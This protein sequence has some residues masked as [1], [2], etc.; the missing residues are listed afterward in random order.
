MQDDARHRAADLVGE[1]YA[2]LLGNGS[3]QAFIDNLSR[4]LPNGKAT[5]FYHDVAVRTGAFSLTSEFDPASVEAYGR[6]YAAL[7]PWMAKAACRPLDLGVRAEQ[8]LPRAELR[9]TEFYADFL[10]PQGVESAVGVTVF[11]EQG[12]NFMLSV[13]CGLV[14]DEE[15]DCAAALLGQLAPHLRQ[16][17]TCYR[18]VGGVTSGHVALDAA[19]DALGVAI[20]ALGR[21]RRVRWTNAA[22]RSLLARGD[23]IGANARGSVQAAHGAVRDV[24]DWGIAAAI[25]GEGAARTSI[26]VRTENGLLA[27]R[28]TCVV[29]ALT[30][31]ERLFAGP[32]VV[33]L[34]ET[35][36]AGA[37]PAEETLRTTFALTPSEARFA[38]ALADG[39]SVTEAAARHG[40][41]RE[42]ARTH[43][44]RIF[45][46]MGVGHQAALVAMVHRCRGL[47]R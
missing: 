36:A 45:A 30:P 5:L 47:C 40:I 19:S 46:K 13:A 11:R 3:W 43:L 9:R 26:A 23:P 12:R 15:M 37:L 1:I 33:L 20:V 32:C 28:L 6:Y 4:A 29:P 22:G 18:R 24:I 44:K 8:M 2:A 10:R 21:D 27:A 31:A 17:F 42:T 41:S 25:R 38:C 35:G 16:A 14:S 34:I 39:A 7:N